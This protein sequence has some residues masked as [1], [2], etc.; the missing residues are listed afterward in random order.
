MFLNNEMHFMFKTLFRETELGLYS[1]K[2]CRC[3]LRKS[4]LAHLEYKKIVQL[5]DP[6]PVN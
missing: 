4:T 2:N 5:D 1:A 6:P 3:Q